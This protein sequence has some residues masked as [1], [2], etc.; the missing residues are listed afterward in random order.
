MWIESWELRR[1]RIWLLA[2]GLLVLTLILFLQDWLAWHATF[3]KYLRLGFL[4]LHAGF[5]RL[6]RPRATL[7]SSMF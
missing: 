1:G 2:A 6:V 7:R 5:Y 4:A 3:L